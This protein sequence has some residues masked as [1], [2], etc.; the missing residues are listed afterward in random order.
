MEVPLPVGLFCTFFLKRF[1]DSMKSTTIDIIPAKRYH[2]N[3]EKMWRQYVKNMK[4]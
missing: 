4:K 3:M 2:P 1:G